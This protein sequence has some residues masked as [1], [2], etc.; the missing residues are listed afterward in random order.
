[1][2]A[3]ALVYVLCVCTA[4]FVENCL[5]GSFVW[6]SYAFWR[7]ALCAYRRAYDDTVA[8]LGGR[9]VVVESFVRSRPLTTCYRPFLRATPGRTEN[10]RDIWAAVRARLYQVVFTLITL[11]VITA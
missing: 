4:C 10:I 3:S 11:A 5:Y 6:S 2:N 1:M 8:V 9:D 7:V